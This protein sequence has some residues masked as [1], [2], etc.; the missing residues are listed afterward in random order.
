GTRVRGQDLARPR[1]GGG[2]ADI[3]QGIRGDGRDRR[4]RR[5][6][7]RRAAHAGAAGAGV[8]GGA[9]VA[10][11]ARGA[12]WGAHSAR[13]R[14]ARVRRAHVAVGADGRWAADA[15]P[16]R[17]GVRR[18]AGVAV[19]A[20]ERVRGASHAGRGAVAGA[21]TDAGVVGAGLAGRL[22]LAG[23]R[24][25]VAGHEVAVVALLAEVHDAVAADVGDLADEDG[26]LVGLQ[27]ATR[28]ARSLN[29]ADV[30]AAGAA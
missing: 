20:G 7:G 11:V 4:R 2:A 19:V 10:A 6:H 8:G 17:T 13:G 16:A 28:E 1:V 26:E 15:D 14:P 22:E 3:H 12:V 9:G 27:S 24:A 30:L 21:A 25:A 29:R 23:R 5:A 18:G